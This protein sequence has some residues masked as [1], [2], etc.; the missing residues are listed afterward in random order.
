MHVQTNIRSH[1]LIKTT[2]VLQRSIIPLS[3]CYLLGN[4]GRERRTNLIQDC[5]HIKDKQNVKQQ[6]FIWDSA[7]ASVVVVVSVLT[8]T[9]KSS[10]NAWESLIKQWFGIRTFGISTFTRS[11]TDVY[12]CNSIPASFTLMMMMMTNIL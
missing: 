1:L 9:E 8:M 6:Q 10:D 11:T 5:P 12:Q 4:V 7:P 2:K 3:T